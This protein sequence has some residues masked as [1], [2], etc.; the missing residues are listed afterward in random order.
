LPISGT[1]G[2]QDAVAGDKVDQAQ[3]FPA[4]FL[5]GAQATGLFGQHGYPLAGTM[6]G[7]QG[8]GDQSLGF[9]VQGPGAILTPL[10]TIHQLA[11][12]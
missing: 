3:G 10:S 11:L 12:L 8:Q 9:S 1:G 6:G 4:L 5:A 2:G 7:I